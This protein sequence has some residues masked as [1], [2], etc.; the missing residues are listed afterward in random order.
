MV[1]QETS[2]INRKEGIKNTRPNDDE[3]DFFQLSGRAQCLC[4]LLRTGLAGAKLKLVETVLDALSDGIR[5]GRMPGLAVVQ[6]DRILDDFL[7]SPNGIN[8][9]ET[10]V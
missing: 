3:T 1:V 8:S 7:G 2:E 4:M 9:G 5:D 6:A 10:G